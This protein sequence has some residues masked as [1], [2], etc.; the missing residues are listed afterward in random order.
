MLTLLAAQPWWV[1]LLVAALVLAARR[2][3]RVRMATLQESRARAAA[4][5]E[6][7]LLQKNPKQFTKDECVLTASGSLP[8][9]TGLTPARHAEPGAMSLQASRIQR[10]G[11]L[12]AAAA[13]TEG[14]SD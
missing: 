9:Q 1:W 5:A 12:Q 8:L 7:E 3:F 4:A 2:V 10:H 11:S 6:S 14:P 13:C